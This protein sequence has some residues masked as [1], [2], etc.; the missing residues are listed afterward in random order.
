MKDL[1]NS[2]EN[3]KKSE[4]SEIIQSRINQFSKIKEKSIDDIFIELC[5]CI[6]TANCGAEKCIEIHD[7]IGEDF[8]NLSESGLVDK[9]K[10]YGYR[11]PNVRAKYIINA[12]D[13]KEKVNKILFSSQ[14][15]LTIRNNLVKTIKGLGYKESSHFLRNIGFSDYAIIDFHIVDLLERYN[16][17]EKPKTMTIRKYHEIE[18]VLMSLGEKVDLTMAELDLYLWYL[19]TGKVLK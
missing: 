9:F 11:F 13:Y 6:M 12:R 7:L 3:L 10:E 8:L 14:E 4:V 18:E 17:I 1:I 16:L 19:E 5:F 15:R 2:L